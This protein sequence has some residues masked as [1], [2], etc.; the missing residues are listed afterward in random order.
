MADGGSS[1]QK[2]ADRFDH[3][4]RVRVVG[5]VLG[6]A[7]LDDPAIAESGVQRDRRRPEDRTAGRTEELEDRLA[8]VAE[9]I[10]RGDRGRFGP[11]LAKDGVRRP[12]PDRP[13]RIGAVGVRS[14][15]VSPTTSDRK[16]ESIVAGSPAANACAA[17]PGPGRSIALPRRRRRAS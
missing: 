7:D 15:A 2:R 14:W 6:A 13:D 16:V 11:E 8:D 9:R 5:G 4:V 10:E 12:D 3:H 17:A 1:G